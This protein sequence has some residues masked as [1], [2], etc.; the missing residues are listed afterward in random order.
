MRTVRRRPDNYLNGVRKVRQIDYEPEELMTVR[1]SKMPRSKPLVAANPRATEPNRWEHRRRA[2][3]GA[4][5]FDRV[6]QRWRPAPGAS[7]RLQPYFAEPEAYP[8]LH[9]RALE[10]LGVEGRSTYS[11]AFWL[12][13]LDACRPSSAEHGVTVRTLDKAL[14]EHPKERSTDA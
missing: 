11:L 13:Y 2:A 7:R 12:R 6:Y 14:W 8:I 10:S 4:T 5:P 9:I 1:T 3:R